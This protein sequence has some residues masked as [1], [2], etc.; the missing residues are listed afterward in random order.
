MKDLFIGVLADV[1]KMNSYPAKTAFLID[2]FLIGPALVFIASR[3]RALTKM[4][5]LTLLAIAGTAIT[6]NYNRYKDEKV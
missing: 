4:E 6:Y 1:L 3:D 5:K 2:L